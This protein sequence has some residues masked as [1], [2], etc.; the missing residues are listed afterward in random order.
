MNKCI[1]GKQGGNKVRGGLESM[2]N[3]TVNGTCFESKKKRRRRKPS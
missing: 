1:A 2:M 3:N